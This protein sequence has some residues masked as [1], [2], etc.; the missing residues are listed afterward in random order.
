M[1][2]K[3][4]KIFKGKFHSA[5]NTIPGEFVTDSKSVIKF[6]CA[7]GWYIIDELQFEGKKK[8]TAEEFLRGWRP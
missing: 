5:P 4:A 2:E 3:T 1:G 8:M 6:A 7:D